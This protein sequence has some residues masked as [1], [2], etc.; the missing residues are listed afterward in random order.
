MG[1]FQPEWMP[2][3]VHAIYTLRLVRLVCVSFFLLLSL[4]WMWGP[5]CIPPKP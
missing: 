5:C 1:I 2:I 3:M 4:V